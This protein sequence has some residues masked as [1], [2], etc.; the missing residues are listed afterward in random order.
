MKL[1][2]V[3]KITKIG[4]SVGITL[5]QEI[6]EKVNLKN[7][8]DVFVETKDNEIIIKKKTQLPDGISADFFEIL[9]KSM[10]EYNETIKA[11]RDK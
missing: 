1:V 10:N 5:P 2:K 11:L 7:G 9:E 4:N 3:R 8:D 6:L